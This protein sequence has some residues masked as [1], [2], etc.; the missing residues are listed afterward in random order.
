[1]GK[2]EVVKRLNKFIEKITGPGISRGPAHL[3][4]VSYSK[5]GEKIWQYLGPTKEKTI[6]TG[7]NL[8][9]IPLNLASSKEILSALPYLK[10]PSSQKTEISELVDAIVEDVSKYVRSRP[11]GKIVT[12]PGRGKYLHEILSN[13]SDWDTV[14]S[15]AND[16]HILRIGF[17]DKVPET[18]RHKKYGL[19]SI[20]HPLKET[21]LYCRFVEKLKQAGYLEKI[22]AGKGKL[23]KLDGLKEVGPE[24]ALKELEKTKKVR[25]ATMAEENVDSDVVDN[26]LRDYYSSFIKD[27]K[28]V[29][30]L[31]KQQKLLASL[32]PEEQDAMVAEALGESDEDL[33]EKERKLMEREKIIR[34]QIYK[35]LSKKQA[36]ELLYPFIHFYKGYELGYIQKT[37]GFKEYLKEYE[38]ALNLLEEKFE[39]LKEISVEGLEEKYPGLTPASELFDF[40]PAEEEVSASLEELEKELKSAEAS[41]KSMETFREETAKKEAEAT[42]PDVKAMLKMNLELFDKNIRDLQDKINKLSAQVGRLR[43]LGSDFRNELIAVLDKYKEQ[44]YGNFKRLEIKLEYPMKPENILLFTAKTSPHLGV[45]IEGNFP[46]VVGKIKIAFKNA[47]EAAKYLGGLYNY[48]F[49]DRKITELPNKHWANPVIFNDHFKNIGW[50]LLETITDKAKVEEALSKYPVPSTPAI[51]PVPI[52]YTYLKKE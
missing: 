3:L 6:P 7:L 32:T 2:E 48:L 30:E 26:L 37:R 5:D 33:T 17:L 13:V 15:Y 49:P 11:E 34:K 52:A 44:L 10:F 42:D 27:K 50:V 29:E 38:R 31:V 46:G 1:M 22:L 45:I 14:K 47:S 51:T 25:E 12:V 40:V 4:S 24:E 21:G 43:I 28:R 36:D 19:V 23:F 41:L 20:L 35:T 18:G 16:N 9:A 39:R 8:V